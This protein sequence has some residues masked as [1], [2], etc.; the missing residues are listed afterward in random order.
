MMKIVKKYGARMVRVYT[1][2]Y[3]EGKDSIERTLSYLEQST[4][5]LN[6]MMN[7][8]LGYEIR[9]KELTGAQTIDYNKARKEIQEYI[10][11]Q[12]WSVDFMDLSD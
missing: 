3:M 10:D 8:F 5:Y 4:Q 12:D 2:N 7:D 6:S 11:D 1:E 9:T